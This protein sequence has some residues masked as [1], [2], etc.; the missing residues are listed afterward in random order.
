MRDKTCIILGTRP[1][2]IK[3]SPVIRACERRGCSCDVDRVFF[4]QLRPP[5]VKDDLDCKPQMKFEYEFENAHWVVCLEL[6][7]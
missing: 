7:G 5:D 2:I 1:E 4:E 3:M 6:G